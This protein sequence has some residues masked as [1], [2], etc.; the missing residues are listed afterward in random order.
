MIYLLSGA[1]GLINKLEGGQFDESDER[2]FE[3]SISNMNLVKWFEGV[4][5]LF[6]L[7]DKQ[8]I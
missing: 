4:N 2:L 5:E 8:A 6:S 1:A 7:S 3:A